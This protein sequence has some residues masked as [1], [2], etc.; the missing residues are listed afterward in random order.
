M[1]IS[2]DKLIIGG[3][4]VLGGLSFL[5]YSQ[6]K[7]DQ[8]LG[9]SASKAALPELKGSDDVDK[10]EITNGSKGSVTLVKTGD[11]WAV[12]KPLAAPASQTNVK[13]L[14]DNVKELKATEI[15]AGAADDE[16]KK[17]YDLDAEH[18]V[19]V[20]GYKGADV[21]FGDSFGKSGGRGEIM[22]VDGKPQILASSGYSSYL[23]AREVDDWRDKEIFKFDDTSVANVTIENKSGKLSFTK[24][25]KWSGTNNGQPI[26]QFDDN[27]V[28]ELLR[29]M[30]ALH[31]EGFGDGK[32]AAETGLDRP[33]GTITVSLK[34]NS[35]TY[36]LRVGAGATATSHY[37][38]KDGDPTMY[39]VSI[40]ILTWATA[41]V[42]KFT[43]A[44]DAGAPTAMANKLPPGHP[45][46]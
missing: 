36:K 38:L 7:K 4:V 27:K 42:S 25:D 29:S 45:Q 15:V 19:H 18:A 21:K 14:L 26:P 12:T 22:M 20:V 5:A 28:G 2:R 37:A 13:Q 8:A 31:A 17:T 23:Y 34:D 40:N 46:K 1:A 32:S 3:V 44:A 39:T 16:T 6:I 33:D 9:S 35:G 41:D 43:K 24:G 11:V 10:L 30:K